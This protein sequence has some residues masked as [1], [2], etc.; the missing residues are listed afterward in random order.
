[1]SLTPGPSLFAAMIM[2]AGRRELAM[3]SDPDRES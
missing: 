2:K 1:M 3:R